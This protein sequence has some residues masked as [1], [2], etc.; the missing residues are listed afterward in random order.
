MTTIYDLPLTLL[1]DIGE[2][3]DRRSLNAF[4]RTSRY[5]YTGLNR[6]LYKLHI[7]YDEPQESCL[8]WAAQAGQISTFRMAHQLGADLN[9]ER[10][11]Q[12][13]PPSPLHTA[14]EHFHPNIVEYILQNGVAVQSQPWRYASGRSYP[15]GRALRAANLKQGVEDVR[16][17]QE[18][19]EILIRYGASLVDEGGPALPLAA[20]LNKQHIVELL[21]QQPTV[22]VNDRSLTG[23]TAL[24]NASEN[25][26]AEL[27]RYLLDQPDINIWSQ[28]AGGTTALVLAIGNGHLDIVRQLV[29]WHGHE[30]NDESMLRMDAFYHALLEGRPNICEY[31]IITSPEIEG[32][33]TLDDGDRTALHLAAL[34]DNVDTIAMLLEYSIVHL[35][36]VDMDGETVLHYLA[37]TVESEGRI[38][39]AD[40]A[41]MLIERGADVNHANR[42]GCT[43]LE[44]A[45]SRDNFDVAMQFLH[46]GADAQMRVESC[47]GHCKWT[48]LHECLMPDHRRPYQSRSRKSLLEMLMERDPTS[49]H[50]ESLIVNSEIRAIKGVPFDGT[51][52]VFAV[53][54]DRH[55]KI[56]QTLLD[57][58]ARTDVVVSKR[59]TPFASESRHSII[60]ALLSMDMPAVYPFYVEELEGVMVTEDDVN[61]VKKRLEMLLSRGARIDEE[62]GLQSVLEYS[63][64]LKMAGFPELLD[65]LLE[66]AGP[67][68]VSVQHVQDLITDY[69]REGKCVEEEG[70]DDGMYV[71]AMDT[72]M[73]LQRW[74]DEKLLPEEGMNIQAG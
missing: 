43:P 50:E 46:S 66:S 8:F 6:H 47:S 52:L 72:A 1:L 3:L 42:H 73:D 63:C 5:Y 31:L 34:S 64:E 70:S 28:V 56:I 11:A 61:F 12:K 57:K 48:P 26:H 23:H 20:A 25:G 13:G 38:K 45:I 39:R 59:W 71:F 60:Q 22:H 18:I 74:M 62:H 21:L 51:P 68:N 65:V 58:G 40:M 32:G 55:P 16:K 33:M 24:H 41:K 14:I 15:L 35:G 2:W 4:V 30:D 36:T 27:A 49:L 29:T 54:Y 17:N 10:Q 44:R 37:T 69:E 7:K 19:L 53:L 9:V 67:R